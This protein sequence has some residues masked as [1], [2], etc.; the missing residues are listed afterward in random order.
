MSEWVLPWIRPPVPPKCVLLPVSSSRWA[1]SMPIAD[2]VRQVEVAVDVERLVVLADLVRLR[3]VRVEVVLAV[4]RAWAGWC[5]SSASADAHRQLDGVAVQHR[6][7]AGQAERDRID[8]GVRLVAEAVGARAEQLGR[9]GQLDVH[10]EADDQLVAV[11]QLAPA[12]GVERLDD[13]VSMVAV[14]AAPRV[15][16]V[17]ARRAPFERRSGAEHRR[18]AER[19]GEHLHADRAAR[20]RRCRTAR[21]SPDGRRGWWGSCTRRTGTSP[22]GCRPSSPIGNATR[23]RRRRQQHVG[24]LVGAVEVVGDQRRTFS[25]WP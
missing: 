9:G 17:R 22:A 24:A 13:G 4:E 5:S 18:L 2:A 20:R 25:A 6:Q 3:H 15:G 10:L 12:S 8:V 1:R 7:R 16:R 11:D 19:A 14:I 21:S 23:R